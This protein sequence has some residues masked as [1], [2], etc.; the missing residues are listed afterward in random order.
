MRILNKSQR[1]DYIFQNHSNSPVA[2]RFGWIE[3]CLT[4]DMQTFVDGINDFLN[5]KRKSRRTKPRGGGNLSLPILVSTGLELVSATF[6]GRTEY[7]NRSG[8]PHYNAVENTSKF[9]KRY[10]P[11]NSGNLPNILW[12]S[13]RNGIT[14]LFVPKTLKRRGDLI[15]FT[16]YV[17]PKFSSR[18]ERHGK[19]LWVRFNSVEYYRALKRAIASYKVDLLSNRMLQMNF[20]KAWK[21]IER[22]VKCID[23]DNEKRSEADFLRK[24]LKTRPSMKLFG[25]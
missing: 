1:F 4:G 10:F 7:M 11:S 23:K 21:S 14:H 18:V 16:F 12:D 22:K 9:I 15:K 20:I 2:N 13:T 8:R 17:N 19:I 5:K 24:R 25:L 3:T 6:V